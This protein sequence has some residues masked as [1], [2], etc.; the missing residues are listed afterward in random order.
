[1]CETRPLFHS[2]TS[3]DS[4]QWSLEEAQVLIA[5]FRLALKDR[6]THSYFEV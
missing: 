1:M 6:K 5:K 2:K 3:A 4:L